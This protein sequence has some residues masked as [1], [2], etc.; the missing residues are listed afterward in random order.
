MNTIISPIFSFV[1]CSSFRF[2]MTKVNKRLG[3]RRDAVSRAN[4]EGRSIPTVSG[5]ELSRPWEPHSAPVDSLARDGIGELNR[6]VE[7]PSLLSLR[8]P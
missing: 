2:D 5:H 3:N 8:I 7:H 4:S 1:D 6:K